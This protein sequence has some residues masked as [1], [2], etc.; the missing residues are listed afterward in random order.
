M[1]IFHWYIL[2]FLSAFI[3][4]IIGQNLSLKYLKIKEDGIALDQLLTI[5]VTLCIGWYIPSR[6]SKILEDKRVIKNNL[7]DEIRLFLGFTVKIK[8]KINTCFVLGIITPLNKTEINLMFEEADL[9]L[10]NLTKQVQII[11]P[12]ICNSSIQA[13][14]AYWQFVTGGNFMNQNYLVI[15][16]NFNSQLM[17]EHYK[18][19]IVF[20]QLAQN[21]QTI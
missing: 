21:I 5:I 19:E 6:L 3:G 1:K 10:D 15:D 9:L 11:D 17:N 14:T 4:L 8:E 13:Y 12:S 7:N 20:K 2:L 16:Q 18:F